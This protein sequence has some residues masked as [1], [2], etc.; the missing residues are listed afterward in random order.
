MAKES[1]LG[2]STLSITESGTTVRDIKNDITNFDMSTPRGVQEVTGLDKL[3]IERLLTLSDFSATYNG[4]FNSSTNPF[5]HSVFKTI[6][7]T[8]VVRTCV[9][10]ISGQTLSVTAVLTDYILTRATSGEFTWSTPAALAG[11]A[12]PTWS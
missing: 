6:S 3:A 11:G 12:V 2:W 7:S 4:I 5:S 9:H 8:N 1:G 10:V